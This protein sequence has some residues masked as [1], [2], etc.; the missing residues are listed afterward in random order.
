MATP[1]TARKILTVGAA[2]APVHERICRD[3]QFGPGH[4]GPLYR[5]DSQQQIAYFS[6]RGPN[7][8]GR[9]RSGS[10]RE[11]SLGSFAQG[12]DGS[13]SLRLRDVVSSPTVAGIA[14]LLYSAKPGGD[15]RLG[16]RRHHP[17]GPRRA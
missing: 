1:G 13:L 11:R 9:V 6:S 16:S 8:D 10:R 3:V 7:A 15:A 2:S 14:A 12:A 4:P 5:P 17:L